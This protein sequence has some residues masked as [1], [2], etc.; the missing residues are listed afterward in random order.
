MKFNI[1]EK[2]QIS[3]KRFHTW[4]RW[5]SFQ[6]AWLKCNKRAGTAWDRHVSVSTAPPAVASVQVLVILNQLK[7]S[8]LSESSR[9]VKRTVQSIPLS[10]SLIDRNLIIL[11]VKNIQNLFVCS[12]LRRHLRVYSQNCIW[13]KCHISYIYSLKMLWMRITLTKCLDEMTVI[14]DATEI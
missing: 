11:R 1:R 12:A 6:L 3:Q 4:W 8:C 13:Y 7:E 9:S 14:V 10:Q 2:T 5:K